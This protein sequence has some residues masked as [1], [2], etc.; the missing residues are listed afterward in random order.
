MAGVGRRAVIAGT[1]TFPGCSRAPAASCH[2]LDAGAGALVCQRGG[3]PAPTTSTGFVCGKPNE[4][5][6]LCWGGL[7]RPGV[8]AVPIAEHPWGRQGAGAMVPERG[9]QVAGGSGDGGVRPG[10]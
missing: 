8:P 4:H 6:G 5:P 1:R 9:T 10:R 2:Q 3:V 7:A